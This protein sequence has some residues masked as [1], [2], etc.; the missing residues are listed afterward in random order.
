MGVVKDGVYYH[1]LEEEDFEPRKRLIQIPESEA[2]EKLK[3]LNQDITTGDVTQ[4]PENTEE[5]VLQ[6]SARNEWEEIQLDLQNEINSL[7]EIMKQLNTLQM[8]K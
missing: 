5:N 1:N 8:T 4:N 2:E 6:S 7:M 3:Q